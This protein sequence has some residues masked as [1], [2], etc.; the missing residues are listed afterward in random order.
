MTGMLSVNNM[1]EFV[2]LVEQIISASLY[3]EKK[4]RIP[5]VLALVGPSGSGKNDIV[6]EL[7]QETAYASPKTYCTKHSD[8][9][10]YLTDEE[11]AK[12][13][14]FE[15]TMYASFIMLQYTRRE[16]NPHA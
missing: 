14:F 9:H 5:S 7:C 3:K 10:K 1:T 6:Q 11:F 12:Q 16:S 15:T 13:N 2:L 4:I 8:K